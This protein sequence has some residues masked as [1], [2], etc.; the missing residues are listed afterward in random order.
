MAISGAPLSDPD[1]GPA[2]GV[3]VLRDRREELKFDRM[4]TE[5]LSCTGHEL[6]TPL[7]HVLVSAATL[8]RRQWPADTQE[9]LEIINKSGHSLERIVE[10]LEFSTAA[11]SGRTVLRSE[12]LDLRRVVNDVLS[13][14]APTVQPPLRLTRKIERGLP[15][16]L[17]D[18]RWLQ[19]ALN[20]LVD[21]A[22]KWSPA[23][24][25]VVISAVRGDNHCLDLSVTDHGV[26]MTAET[27]KRAFDD[28]EQGDSSDTRQH[29]GLGLGLP[30]VHRVV[31]GHRGDVRWATPPGGG[32]RMTLVLPTQ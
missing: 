28:F 29:G 26:G 14:W 21:N 13:E 10:L 24:G 7:G 23:G 27:A 1:G 3:F 11:V 15:P 6:R 16:V 32:T 22:I 12:P 18:A 4:K 20:E 30:F 9:L 5:L 8:L 17:G 2:G 25:T 31:K 19:R